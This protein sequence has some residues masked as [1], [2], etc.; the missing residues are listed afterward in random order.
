VKQQCESSR[1]PESRSYLRLVL[2]EPRAN[3]RECR[4]PEQNTSEHFLSVPCKAPESIRKHMDIKSAVMLNVGAVASLTLGACL[5]SV[6]PCLILGR[7]TTLLRFNLRTLPLPAHACASS[8]LRPYL[9]RVVCLCVLGM[10]LF[11]LPQWPRAG[12]YGERGQ[13]LKCITFWGRL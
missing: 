7:V 4:T 10:A 3:K 8:W 11:V 2:L 1:F 5:F 6:L 12:V 9:S 13:G